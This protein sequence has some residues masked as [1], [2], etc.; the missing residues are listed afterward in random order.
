LD[1][2]LVRKS[3]YDLGACNG[4]A[5]VVLHSQGGVVNSQVNRDGKRR[6]HSVACLICGFNVYTLPDDAVNLELGSIVQ[7]HLELWNADDPYIAGVN[8]ER[9][10]RD[11]GIPAAVLELERNQ[12]LDA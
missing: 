12:E 3:R 8:L 7:P 2:G 9:R 1:D 6:I 11:G 4:R 5:E 10:R